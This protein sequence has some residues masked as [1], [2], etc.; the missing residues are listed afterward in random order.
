MRV[1]ENVVGKE[2]KIDLV[3]QRLEEVITAARKNSRNWKNKLPKI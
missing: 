2:E 3:W 1:K